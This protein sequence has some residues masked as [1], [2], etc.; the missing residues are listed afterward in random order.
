MVQVTRRG[1]AVALGS[2]VF[3]A[4]GW[5]LGYRELVA[6]GVVGVLAL[7]TGCLWVFVRPRLSLTREISQ[8]HVT[9]DDRAEGRISLQNLAHRP[10][11]AFVAMDQF[12]GGP[13]PVPIPRLAPG[14]SKQSTYP[15]P[16]NQRRVAQVG[17]IVIAR[18]DPFDLVTVE[19]RYG[20]TETLWIHP[21]R[22]AVAPLPSSRLRSL[23]GPQADTAPRGSITFDRIREYVAGDDMRLIHWPSTAKV[24]ELMVREHIDTSL[25]DVTV[26]IDTAAHRHDHDSFEIC[27]EVAA[28]VLLA[29]SSRHFP[30]R[31]KTTDGRSS[32]GPGRRSSDQQILDELAGLAPD[33]QGGDARTLTA[34]LTALRRERGGSTLAVVTTVADLTDLAAL[35]ALRRRFGSLVLVL[36][37]RGEAPAAI[38]APGVRVIEAS[39]GPEFADRWTL[40]SR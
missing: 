2:P 10:S 13:I 15:L 14:A 17:P 9:V 12:P 1:R 18:M 6:L 34:T 40:L 7:A 31:L 23:D 21:K 35:G 39:S 30:A 32:G 24:G 11:T 8:V 36:I 29:S 5:V 20:T 37:T 27:I 3:V 38:H 16:T 28:T 33:Q 22:Y 4:L 19:Q 25:P 26:V